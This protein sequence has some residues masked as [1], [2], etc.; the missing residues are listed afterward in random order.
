[1]K[2]IRLVGLCMVAMTTMGAVVAA[3]ALA[4]SPEYGRCLGHGGGKFKDG[5]CKTAAVPG[6]E[7]FEFYPAYGKA[8]NGEEKPLVKKGY[9]IHSESTSEHRLVLQATGEELGVKPEIEC[10]ED[11][12]HGDI[13]SNKEATQ[14]GL[15]YKGCFI[16]F[17]EGCTTP[18]AEGAEIKINDLV[19]VIGI[20][21][22]GYNKETKTEEPVNDKLAIEFSPKEGEKWAAF[23][24]GGSVDYVLRGHLMNPIKTNEMANKTAAKFVGTG[25]NQKPEHF[26]TGIDRETGK[27]SFGEELSWEVDNLNF[28]T[29]F[30]EWGI[31]KLSIE[32]YEEKVEANSIV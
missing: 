23:V 19:G 4:A 29:Q 7:K 9:T 15:V 16:S 27:E 10:K 18:G 5:N 26:S 22:R 14:E 17:A 1:M 32:T 28:G 13:I 2:R 24:C 30:E 20:E 21:K 31:T 12:A 8:A 25:G 6:E 3:S 11:E